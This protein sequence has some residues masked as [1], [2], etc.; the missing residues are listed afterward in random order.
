M[1]LDEALAILTTYS[2]AFLG[3]PQSLIRQQAQDIVRRYADESMARE[4][5]RLE[6]LDTPYKPVVTTGMSE[7]GRG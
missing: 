6:G 1:N 2:S 3:R 5:R 7:G 4:I